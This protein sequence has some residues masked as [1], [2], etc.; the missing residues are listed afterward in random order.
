[1]STLF[2][3]PVCRDARSLCGPPETSTGILASL[4]PSFTT[5]LGPPDS[6]C[7]MV[8]AKR[9]AAVPPVHRH[10]IRHESGPGSVG[11][12]LS[13]AWRWTKGPALL[14]LSLGSRAGC[15]ADRQMQ[16]LQGSNGSTIPKAGL[17]AV[18]TG[19]R[20]RL[21]SLVLE[22]VGGQKV[23]WSMPVE[24]CMAQG[25]CARGRVA[26]AMPLTAVDNGRIGRTRER[27]QRR[28]DSKRS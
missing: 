22:E 15:P 3:R 2:F 28:K 16:R 5:H 21:A 12:T 7:E 18:L 17:G 26:L 27:M 24:R 11:R 4:L 20:N 6:G 25:E 9:Q 14:R 10:P 19:I 23:V 1:M 8:F 13:M